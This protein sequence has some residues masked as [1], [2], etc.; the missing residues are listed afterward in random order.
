M[1]RRESV[2]V[3]GDLCPPE[4]LPSPA[5]YDDICPDPIAQSPDKIKT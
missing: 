5:A 1:A 2:V 3:F 4:P